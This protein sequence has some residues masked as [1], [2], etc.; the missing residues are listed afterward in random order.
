MVRAFHHAGEANAHP[1]HRRRPAPRAQ[2]T[3]A[4]RSLQRSPRHPPHAARVTDGRS[5]GRARSQAPRRARLRIAGPSSS[6]P[7]ATAR[8]S[9]P[10]TPLLAG[11]APGIVRACHDDG[12]RGRRRPLLVRHADARPGAPA[13]GREGRD[14]R[15]FPSSSIS[16]PAKPSPSFIGPATGG[17]RRRRSSD[18]RAS[19]A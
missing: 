7:I 3:D 13:V 19:S 17:S 8:S 18:R 11:I 16:A 6:S 1:A 10:R 9:G 12:P 15:R 2:Q 14:P 5:R 4:G